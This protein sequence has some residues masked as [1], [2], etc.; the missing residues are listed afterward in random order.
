LD[1]MKKVRYD[2][3]YMFKYSPREGT[4]A[5][6]MDDDVTEEVKSRRLQEIIQLQQ[7]ISYQINQTRVG[8]EEMVL[9]EGLSKKSDEF[10]SGRTD[11][12][13]VVII[14]ND[15]KHKI[16]DYVKVIINRATHATLFGNVLQNTASAQNR[17]ALTG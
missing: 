3:A 5:F 4:K 14:P 1:V 12:N 17:L 11:S 10:L 8:N 16:G 15:R 9:V 6:K 13:K 2:G 7:K